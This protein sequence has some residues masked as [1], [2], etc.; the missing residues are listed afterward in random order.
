[1][2]LQEIS[3]PVYKLSKYKPILENGDLF[4]V[5][6]VSE[7]KD[8]LK[9]IDSTNV[10][11]DTLAIRRL[12]LKVAGVELLNLNQAIFFLADLIKIAKKDLWFIDSKGKLFQYTKDRSV[13]L[14]FKRIEKV[15]HMQTGGSIVV[16]KGITPRF[17]T[18]FKVTDEYK[19]AGLLKV[20]A[21]SYILY[22]V[23]TEEHKS[24]RRKI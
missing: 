16:V 21:K 15:I 7:D 17:K 23:Y 6:R 13:P 2:K 5:F 24:T 10:S 3:F 8:K 1:M 19:F 4:Y 18:L 12:K 22:G 14:I 20:D 9:V 11:G